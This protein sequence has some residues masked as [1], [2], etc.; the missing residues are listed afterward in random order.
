MVMLMNG[1]VEVEVTMEQVA[2]GQ[3]VVSDTRCP[4][5]LDCDWSERKQ[6]SGPKEDKVL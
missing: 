6:G 1:D 4:A 3:Y 2:Q 5:L